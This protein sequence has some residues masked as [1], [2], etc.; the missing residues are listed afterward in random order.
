M[1]YKKPIDK[2]KDE[3]KDYI[4]ITFTPDEA[5]KEIDAL[6]RIAVDK[7]MTGEEKFEWVKNKALDLAYNIWKWALPRLI[8]MAYD[9]MMN[10][11]PPLVT[12]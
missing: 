2:L 1:E 11:R 10:R 6:V 7:T 3:F 12:N 5:I 4:A 8:Q 9:A